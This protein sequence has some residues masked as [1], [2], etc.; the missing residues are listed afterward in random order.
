VTRG[1]GSG[2]TTGDLAGA[3]LIDVTQTLFAL[4]QCQ[5]GVVDSHGEIRPTPGD[6]LRVQNLL[7]VNP[8]VG[9]PESGEPVAAEEAG[10]SIITGGSGRFEDAVGTGLC[11]ISAVRATEGSSTTE[12]RCVYDM[13]IYPEEA[14]V[15]AQA[16][17]SG[18]ELAEG[19]A[20]DGAGSIYLYYLVRNNSS[21]A[22]SGLEI[23]FLNKGKVVLT[24]LGPGQETTNVDGDWFSGPVTI[25]PGEVGRY[26]L[27]LRLLDAGDLENFVLQPT[28]RGESASN[29]VQP[30]ELTIEVIR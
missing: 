19:I 1:E 18:D 25:A 12:G 26:R 10:I 21:Q 3:F 24:V 7:P 30:Q 6:S 29:V 17:A 2:T 15:T 5:I 8:G 11:E 16:I 13:V 14:P 28:I 22:I 4:E 9:D 20:A 23:G 27:N